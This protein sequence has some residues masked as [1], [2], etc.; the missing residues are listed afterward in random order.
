MHSQCNIQIRDLWDSIRHRHWTQASALALAWVLGPGSALG[1]G[2]K[3]TKCFGIGKQ[4][5]NV[6]QQYLFNLEVWKTVE[7]WTYLFIDKPWE[8]VGEKMG[9][10]HACHVWFG[11]QILES[12]TASPV[13]Q[14]RGGE[15]LPNRTRQVNIAKSQGGPEMESP[16]DDESHHLGMEQTSRLINREAER[17]CLGNPVH[18]TSDKSGDARTLSWGCRGLENDKICHLCNENDGEQW[19]ACSMLPHT[20]ETG[21]S[22]VSQHPMH[23]KMCNESSYGPQTTITLIPKEL[24]NS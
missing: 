7:W 5:G 22:P 8:Y 18:G 2:Q 6:Y 21:Y 14:G 4:D 1:M 11:S 19:A 10:R 15:G 17:P 23:P 20:Y 16:N 24:F 9:N 13:G 3:V 12:Q